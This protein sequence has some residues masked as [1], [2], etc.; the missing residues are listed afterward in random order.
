MIRRMQL[1]SGADALRLTGGS[2]LRRALEARLRRLHGRP[3]FVIAGIGS[4]SIARIRFAD[5]TQPARLVGP[6]EILTLSGT[7]SRDGSHL[8]ITIADRD[9]R[10]RAGHV[11]SGCIVHTTA[12]ILVATIKGRRFNRRY[13]SATGY[14]E[15]FVRRATP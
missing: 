5:R 2:D 7:L 15:L 11:A 3:G 1:I 4:L 14:R 12:E 9:G 13:D 6:F 8:H 10:V